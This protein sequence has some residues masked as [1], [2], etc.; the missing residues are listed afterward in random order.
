MTSGNLRN[1]IERVPEFPSLADD[2]PDLKAFTAH[3]IS[4]ALQK[5]KGCDRLAAE[6]LGMCFYT[7]RYQRRKLRDW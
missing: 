2:G 3:F 7:F 1:I 4:E 5:A 6:L